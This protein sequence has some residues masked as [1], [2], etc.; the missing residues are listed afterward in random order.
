MAQQMDGDAD[1]AAE[2]VIS[3]MIFSVF[4]LFVFIFVFKT[5][6]LV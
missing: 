3:T 2:L 5:L 6:G 1:L 4:T